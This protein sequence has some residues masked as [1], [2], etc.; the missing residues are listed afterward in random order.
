MN[1]LMSLTVQFQSLY[2]AF[3]LYIFNYL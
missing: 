1:I 2:L 3:N